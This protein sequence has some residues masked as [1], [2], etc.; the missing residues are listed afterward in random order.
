[1]KERAETVAGKLT[2]SSSEGRGACVEAI[3]PTLP[4]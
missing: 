2:I 1:M 4:G 3:V